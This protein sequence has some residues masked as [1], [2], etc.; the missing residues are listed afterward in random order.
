MNEIIDE[1]FQHR[2]ELERA[3]EEIQMPR[4]AFAIKRFVINQHDTDER[5]YEQCVL[6][7][8]NAYDALRTAIL[9]RE[10]ILKELAEY[11]DDEKSQIRKAIKEIQLRQLERAMIGTAREL[12][13]LYK[14]W[15]EDFPH[16]YTREELEAA[17]EEYWMK[18][19]TR[20]ANQD[21]MALGRISQGNLDALRQLGAYEELNVNLLGELIN[22]LRIGE[23][24]EI[25]QI[26]TQE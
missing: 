25:R 5:K 22:N 20:Q 7:M 12:I 16:H 26:S 6:E 19:L 15:R 14:I 8:Q 17:Q 1:I 10:L 2:D 24:H 18:R 9:R 23:D 21:L 13:V 3:F 4:S 11:G